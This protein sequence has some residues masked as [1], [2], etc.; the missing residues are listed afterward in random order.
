MKRRTQPLLF[1]GS[2]L[3][4]WLPGDHYFLFSSVYKIKLPILLH[5]SSALQ[6][7]PFLFLS[8]D[9]ALMHFKFCK[10][11]SF[12]FYIY[13]LYYLHWC[14]NT[15]ELYHAVSSPEADCKIAQLLEGCMKGLIR[16]ALKPRVHYIMPP[17]VEASSSMEAEGEL[18]TVQKGQPWCE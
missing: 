18:E 13:L 15:S 2:D 16:K 9:C 1:P 7:Y 12:S 4:L 5:P 8:L 10:S 3:F 14:I 17:T 11:S 6:D